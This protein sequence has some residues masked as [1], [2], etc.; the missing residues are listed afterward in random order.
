MVHRNCSVEIINN[1]DNYTLANPRVYTDHGHCEVPPAPMV[2][3][4]STGN[5]Y[6]NKTTGAATGAVGVFT[7]DLFNEQYQNY[8]HILAIMFSVPF[9]RDLYSNCFAVGIFARGTEC[10][11]NLYDIMYNGVEDCFVRSDGN[12]SSSCF[13]GEYVS[14]SASMSESHEAVLRVDISDNY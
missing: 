4:G 6:F 12:G 5:A 8:S 2:P 14:V 1:S 7:Y 11:Y 3:A 9:D 10:D 13:Q